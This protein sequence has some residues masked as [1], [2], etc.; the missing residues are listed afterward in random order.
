M[1]KFLHNKL[2]IGF[3]NN[4]TSTKRGLIQGS[5][6]SPYLFN[7]YFEEILIKLKNEVGVT[8]Y[9]YADDLLFIADN[10]DDTKKAINMFE[11]WCK[12]ENMIINKA[13]NKSGIVLIQK[14]RKNNRLK[15]KE[16]NGILVEKNYKYL[17][18]IISETGKIKEAIQEVQKKTNY[19]A[20]KLAPVIKSTSLR[21]KANMI[22]TFI[23]PQFNML[24]PLA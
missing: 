19:I 5:I 15:I 1:L 7:I 2:R 24:A 20:W 12:K 4:F 13:K 3:N 9:A 21:F 6:I 23:R 10:L 16:I 22:N 8:I 11:D 14:S 18:T 17:G